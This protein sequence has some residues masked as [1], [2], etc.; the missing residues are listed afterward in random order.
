VN[1]ITEALAGIQTATERLLASAAVLTDAQ[2]REPSLL[3]GWTRGHVLAHI[4]RN[5]DGLANL[6]RWASTRTEIPMYKSREARDADIEAGA[7]RGAAELTADVR[8]SAASFAQQAA[9]VPETGWTVPV[10]ALRGD[11]FP[12][13]GVLT[14]RLSEVEIHH[15]D[16]AA[17]YG[18]GDWPEDFVSGTLPRVAEM[19]AGRADAPACRIVADG[20]SNT[21]EIGLAA[22]AG[23]G[24]AGDASTDG[25]PDTG[26]VPLVSGPAYELLAWLLG[27]STGHGLTVHPASTVPVMPPWR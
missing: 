15:V 24:R 6:L 11:P 18:P 25:G 17:G 19:F 26:T 3:P 4:A 23:P 13:S 12:A 8:D 10:R 20:M 27:R 1:E 14:R 22:G 16:L 21:L 9:T 2:V 5:A 7:A